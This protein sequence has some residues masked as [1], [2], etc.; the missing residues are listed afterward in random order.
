MLSGYTATNELERE[1]RSPP[2][3]R[4]AEGAASPSRRTSTGS[5][6]SLIPIV[7]RVDE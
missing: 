1:A 4:L 2:F 5:D 3:A 6:A 7:L